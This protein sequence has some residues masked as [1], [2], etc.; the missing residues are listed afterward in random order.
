M[1]CSLQDEIE[2]VAFIQLFHHLLLTDKTFDGF[3]I[4]LIVLV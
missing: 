1:N 2:N 4:T 3:R